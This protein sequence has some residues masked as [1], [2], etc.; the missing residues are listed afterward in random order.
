MAEARIDLFS[1]A[2][3][4]GSIDLRMVASDAERSWIEAGFGK[5]RFGE[6]DRALAI[7]P[8]EAVLVWTPR[9][10]DQLGAV[11][12]L[13]VQE[14]QDQFVD[15]GEAYITWR[16]SPGAPVRFT[17]RAGLYFPLISLEHD[18]LDWAM[19]DTLTPS[20]INSWVGEE[21]KVVGA[22][23]TGRIALGTGDAAITLG[24]FG[25]NDKSGTLLAL[26]GWALHDLKSTV[27]MK[28]PLS[29]IG[30]FG[31]A[32]GDPVST[33]VLEIDDRAG[34]YGRL[35]WR[36]DPSVTLSA[37][38]YDN[39]GDRTSS[40]R[41]EGA[42]DTRFVAA[43]AGWTADPRTRLRAQVLVGDTQVGR[44][45]PGFSMIWV[46]YGSAYVSI[47]RDLGPGAFTA[48]LDRFSVDDLNR[49]I[50]DNND[51]AGWASTLAYRWDFRPGA[52][53]ILEALGIDSH[54]PSRTR[55][56]ADPDQTD[57]QLQAAYRQGF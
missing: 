14:G 25:S 4:S 43:G 8:A 36:P 40:V 31:R 9:L 41:R 17:A 55:L 13:E 28:H 26:R 20:A 33:A 5:T 1:P 48:R 24:V 30:D 49:P 32:R 19:S 47:T 23:A 11:L 56:G 42:W 6:G 39:A 2:R 16:G 35:E 18:G 38:G 52:D 22:E 46:E 3:F 27:S 57:L 12:S 7:V 34:V 15:V 50:G 10:S 51:E 53:I 37:F 21:L 29:P 45:A 44:A 54:R